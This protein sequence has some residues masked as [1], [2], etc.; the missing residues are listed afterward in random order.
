MEGEVCPL[1]RLCREELGSI[2]G[3]GGEAGCCGG[4]ERLAEAVTIAL[5]WEGEKEGVALEGSGEIETDECS[6]DSFSGLAVVEINEVGVSGDAFCEEIVEGTG[7]LVEI[8]AKEG[9]VREQIAA[10][11]DGAEGDV[12]SSGDVLPLEPGGIEF[13]REGCE[14]CWIV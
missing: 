6:A 9:W 7:A 8:E 12:G 14:G 4:I 5:W 1:V 10:Q 3:G 11:R 13:F 2:L